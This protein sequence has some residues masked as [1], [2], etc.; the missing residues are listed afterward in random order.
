MFLYEYKG[1]PFVTS[2]SQSEISCFKDVSLI[3][4]IRNTSFVK[5]ALS[6]IPLE[7][8]FSLLAFEKTL[9]CND[10]N[11]NNHQK[12]WLTVTPT[13]T[14]I[15]SDN[16]QDTPLPVTSVGICDDLIG[17]IEKHSHLH[18]NIDFCISISNLN[19]LLGAS[20]ARDTINTV[21]ELLS[22]FIDEKTYPVKTASK[23][24][25]SENLFIA[26]SLYMCEKGYPIINRGA[27]LKALAEKN[28]IKKRID[29]G[30]IIMGIALDKFKS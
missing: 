6:H 17:F 4:K 30:Y 7:S 29:K 24:V 23:S 13:S 5:N 25:G 19:M 20:P 1:R 12:Y 16:L 9:N 15:T 3:G 28:I 14:I 2:C 27:F 8:L 18:Q 22:N 21:G 10:I 11:N 26:F